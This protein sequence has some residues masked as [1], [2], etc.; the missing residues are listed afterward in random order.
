MDWQAIVACSI[1]VVCYVAATWKSITD[2][3]PANPRRWS[4]GGLIGSDRRTNKGG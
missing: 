4:V 2:C 3:R 1:F